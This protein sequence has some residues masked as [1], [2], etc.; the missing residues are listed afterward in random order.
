MVIRNEIQS[1]SKKKECMK[2]VNY[3]KLF[4]IFIAIDTE[5]SSCT[6]RKK[7]LNYTTWSFLVNIPLNQNLLQGCLLNM[8]ILNSLISSIIALIRNRSLSATKSKIPG[9]ITAKGIHDSGDKTFDQRRTIL[10]KNSIHTKTP[11]IRSQFQIMRPATIN[12]TPSRKLDWITIPWLRYSN[13]EPLC[14]E[15]WMSHV[16]WS[17]IINRSQRHPDDSWSAISS[18]EVAIPDPRRLCSSSAHPSQ[19][20][21]CCRTTDNP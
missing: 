21:T 14:S 4:A 6:C 15:R 3:Q 12:P 16:V 5:P 19:I 13:I 20:S 10:C 8:V 7:T 11:Y 2:K 1:E 18:R 17:S 9:G